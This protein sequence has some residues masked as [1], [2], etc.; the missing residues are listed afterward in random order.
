MRGPDFA[1]GGSCAGPATSAATC[2]ASRWSVVSGRAL[3]LDNEIILHEMDGPCDHMHQGALPH[4]PLF[5][6]A[7]VIFNAQRFVLHDTTAHSLS[8]RLLF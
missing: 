1:E 2:D 4:S 3:W 7:F 6:H 8:V 5:L